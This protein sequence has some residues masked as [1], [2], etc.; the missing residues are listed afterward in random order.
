M[1]YEQGKMVWSNSCAVFCS[2]GGSDYLFLHHQPQS[3]AAGE[4]CSAR[5]GG[6]RMLPCAKSGGAG[7]GLPP[8]VC[9]GSTAGRLGQ[10][11]CLSGN[12][13]AQC[14]QRRTDHPGLC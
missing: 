5:N 11:V 13:A 2:D 4:P 8:P 12:P 7:A 14:Q 10:G 6:G 1:E 9:G 3:P